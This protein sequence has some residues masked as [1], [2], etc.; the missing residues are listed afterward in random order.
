ML[1]AKCIL[2]D[3]DGTLY[4]SRDYS[5]RLEAAI[6]AIVASRLR[7]SEERANS[8][9]QEKRGKIGT[10]TGALQSLN[11][12][13]RDFF[14][15]VTDRI[16]PALYLSKDLTLLRVLNE[17]RNRGFKLG[18]VSNSG[19]P[20]VQKILQAIGVEE[21]IFHSIITSN[22][23]EPKPSPEP[24]L[25]ALRELGCDRESAVYVGDRTEAELRPAQ[26]LRIRTILVSSDGPSKS[27][28]AN[29]V[30]QSIAE[31]PRIVTLT[32]TVLGHGTQLA[33]KGLPR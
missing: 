12:D 4:N 25:L 30:V 16:D 26:E 27:P 29:V 21:S 17:L 2:F 11:I 22:E 7:L 33:R 5:E 32:G 9:L 6:V 31:I 24:F 1:R 18:L 13:R 20:L 10:L 3:L 8:I 19:R 14:E 15:T 28:W 23:A